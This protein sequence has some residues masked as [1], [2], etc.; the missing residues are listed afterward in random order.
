MA[1]KAKGSKK[2]DKGNVPKETAAGSREERKPVKNGNPPEE[3]PEVL[4][5]MTTAGFQIFLDETLLTAACKAVEHYLKTHE[6]SMRKAQL[7]SI[8]PVLQSGGF[9]ALRQLIF[10]QKEKNSEKANKLFWE[11]VFKL[12]DH[13]PTEPGF[14]FHTQVEQ[15]L[16]R[17]GFLQEPPVDVEKTEKNK[18]KNANKKKIEMVK[19]HAAAVYFEHFV[20]HYFFMDSRKNGNK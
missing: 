14:S 20:N 16:S 6:R 15:E 2:K 7:H 10:N 11:F 12:I 17:R 9:K 8:A 4:A 13:Q 5:Y 18:V 19:N 3:Y 1:R